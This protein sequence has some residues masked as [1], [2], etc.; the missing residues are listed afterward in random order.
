MAAGDAVKAVALYRE[1]L[2]SN[3]NEP[4]LCYKLS[5]ALDKTS[6][7]V[8]EKA[9][10]KRAIELDPEL[11]EAQN[12]MGFLTARGGD[13]HPADKASSRTHAFPRRRGP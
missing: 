13:L 11:A 4:I 2:A 12:Q 6:D 7:L 9:A 8:E 5:R 10:L 3:P 1:A